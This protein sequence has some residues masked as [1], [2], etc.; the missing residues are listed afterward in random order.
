MELL[1]YLWFSEAAS[2]VSVSER[3]WRGGGGVKLATNKKISSL[4]EFC[5]I[6]T[7]CIINSQTS[8]F[9]YHCLIL[10]A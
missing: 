1:W 6:M 3:I 8:P 7:V 9:F 10:Y 2:L 5:D 4:A